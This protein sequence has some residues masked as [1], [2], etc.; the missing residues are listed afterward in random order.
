MEQIKEAMIFVIFKV[1]FMYSF[2]CLRGPRPK[3]STVRERLGKWCSCFQYTFRLFRN[4][5]SI[6]KAWK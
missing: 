5:I 4:I 3:Y 2:L 1:I 6:S